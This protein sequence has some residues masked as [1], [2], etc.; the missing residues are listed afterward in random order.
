M[1]KT[2]YKFYYKY[3]SKKNYHTNHQVAQKYI[4][5]QDTSVKIF[6][7]TLKKYL[8]FYKNKDICMTDREFKNT[9]LN[10]HPKNLSLNNINIKNKNDIND[11][12]FNSKDKLLNP[13][14]CKDIS[15]TN[16]FKLELL[17]DNPELWESLPDNVHNNLMNDIYI[18]ELKYKSEWKKKTNSGLKIDLFYIVFFNKV[19][20]EGKQNWPKYIIRYKY[21]PYN[22]IFLPLFILYSVKQQIKF[23]RYYSFEDDNFYNSF[24]NKLFFILDKNLI[25]NSWVDLPSVD[26]VLRKYINKE[27]KIKNIYNY[28]GLD[29]YKSI[30][31]DRL[32]SYNYEY[33]TLILDSFFKKSIFNSLSDPLDNMSSNFCFVVSNLNDLLKTYNKLNKN[34]LTIPTIKTGHS[35]SIHS[36]HELE[37]RIVKFDEDFRQ[38][39]Y[40]Y[41]GWKAKVSNEQKPKLIYYNFNNIHLKL[42]E[43]T[44]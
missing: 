19:K 21:I 30:T 12:C 34:N 8:D 17:N 22:K 28:L 24:A 44:W 38:Y 13:L 29:I 11:F 41:H 9:L 3:L 33:M 25:K 35:N 16:A 40:L 43:V 32:G 5:D 6:E 39:M 4:K 20:A 15:E 18:H 42:G 23:L 31:K 2:L 7:I 10:F 36:I 37:Y 26:D 14:F 27:A 1:H